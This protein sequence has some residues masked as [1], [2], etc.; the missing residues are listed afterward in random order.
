MRRRADEGD[1]RTVEEVTLTNG[2]GVTARILSWGALLRVLEVPD[3][4][5][6]A[7]DVVLGSLHELTPEAI[8]SVVV[9]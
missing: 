8:E 3:R 9:A 5:G 6:K 7:A 1:G 4:T 2:K